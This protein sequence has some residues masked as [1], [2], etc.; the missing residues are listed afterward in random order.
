M[1]VSQLVQVYTG[2]KLETELTFGSK[3]LGEQNL[4]PQN[5]SLACE[6]FLA[7]HNQGP[8]DSGS[9]FTSALAA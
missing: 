1:D 3:T 5:V 9:L 8:R 4:P 2:R 7:K 6:L